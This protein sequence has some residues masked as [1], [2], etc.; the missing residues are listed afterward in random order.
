M[1]GGVNV[2][3]R[4]QVHGNDTFVGIALLM[5]VNHFDLRLFSRIVPINGYVPVDKIYLIWKYSIKTGYLPYTL[6]KLIG[7][8]V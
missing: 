4:M 5:V 3:A 2:G 8:M 7:L 6:W 1:K